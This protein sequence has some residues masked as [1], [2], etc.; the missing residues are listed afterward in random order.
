MFAF[1]PRISV[2][3]PAKGLERVKYKYVNIVLI[4]SRYRL[5]FY[6]LAVFV[7]GEGRLWRHTS[8]GRGEGIQKLLLLMLLRLF[9]KHCHFRRERRVL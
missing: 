3:L 2:K 5:L 7:F 4:F 9:V 8:I 1:C 6:L